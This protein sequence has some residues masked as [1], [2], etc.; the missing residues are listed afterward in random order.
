MTHLSQLP[1]EIILVIYHRLDNID[2]VLRLGR[3]CRRAHVVLNSVA[4]RLSIFRSIIV[5]FLTQFLNLLKDIYKDRSAV[6]P[7]TSTIYGYINFGRPRSISRPDLL[8]S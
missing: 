5:R 6:R 4:H 7:I 2:D 3:S 8:R 1:T